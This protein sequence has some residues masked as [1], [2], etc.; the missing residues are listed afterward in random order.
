MDSKPVVLPQTVEVTPKFDQVVMEFVDLPEAQEMENENG[1]KML[2]KTIA[3]LVMKRANGTEEVLSTAAFPN[4]LTEAQKT[5]LAEMYGKS[6]KKPPA[7]VVRARAAKKA[8]LLSMEA[9]RRKKRK[10]ARA[11]RKKTR[12][13]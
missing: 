6:L 5:E 7:E 2:V 13:R 1:E 4:A 3:R 12:A 8:K 11:A 10:E 9:F